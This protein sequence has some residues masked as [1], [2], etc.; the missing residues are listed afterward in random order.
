MPITRPK[1]AAI[2][3]PTINATGKEIAVLTAQDLVMTALANAPTAIKP[4]WPSA[5][6]PSMP[7]VRF[8]LTAMMI[9]MQMLKR[10]LR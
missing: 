8:R 1:T 2:R 5:N 7:V 9:L 6:S 4:A 3:P 10:M